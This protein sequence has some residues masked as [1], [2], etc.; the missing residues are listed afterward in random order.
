MNEVNK[1]EFQGILSAY[2]RNFG[3]IAITIT[4]VDDRQRARP[5]FSPQAA[6][7]R[8]REIASQLAADPNVVK[9]FCRN[10]SCQYCHKIRLD[11]EASRTPILRRCNKCGAPIGVSDQSVLITEGEVDRFAQ[12]LGDF[13]ARFGIRQPP[14][15][16]ITN[17]DCI[18]FREKFGINDDPETT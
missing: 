18:L 6:H 16:P 17:A 10:P 7:T 15:G 9:I 14:L 12:Q 13:S 5:R 2:R 3:N 8:L 4:A 1:R 11:I